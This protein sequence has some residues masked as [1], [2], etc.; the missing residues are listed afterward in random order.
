MHPCLGGNPDAW[1]KTQ[2]TRGGRWRG[3]SDGRGASEAS[4]PPA[5]AVSGGQTSTHGGGPAQAGPLDGLR[6]WLCQGPQGAVRSTQAVEALLQATAR[7]EDGTNRQASGDSGTSENGGTNSESS[8]APGGSMIPRSTSGGDGQATTPVPSCQHGQPVT[9]RDL[10]TSA[11]RDASSQPASKD[12]ETVTPPRGAENP[13]PGEPSGAVTTV[14]PLTPDGELSHL[15]R[16][17]APAALGAGHPAR[18]CSEMGAPSG[19]GRAKRSTSA[20]DRHNGKPR[21]HGKGQLAP[22]VPGDSEA[23]QARPPAPQAAGG[24]ALE[25]RS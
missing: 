20:H 16:E 5:G 25:K 8:G 22:G 14:P 13:T 7:K 12:A 23:Q 9:A 24:T 3:S 18:S 19:G 2:P 11:T 4:C 1:R 10:K 6:D 17:A 21:K 15:G